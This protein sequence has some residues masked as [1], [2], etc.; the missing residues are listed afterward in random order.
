MLLVFA[1]YCAVISIPALRI[2]LQNI[3]HDSLLRKS[4]CVSETS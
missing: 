2:L 4:K 3:C 1:D